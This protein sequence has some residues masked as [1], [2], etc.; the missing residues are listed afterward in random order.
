MKGED[1]V[2]IRNIK[3]Y[4]IF[5]SST[6]KDLIEE[7]KVVSNAILSAGHIPMGMELF[8]PNGSSS[9]DIIKASIDNSD[10]LVLIIAG[11][12]GSTCIDEGIE[13]SYVEMEYD[14][15]KK[16][17]K[18]I[19]LFYHKDISKLPMYKTEDS[20]KRKKKLAKFLSKVQEDV[21]GKEWIDVNELEKSVIASMVQIN[22]KEYETLGW[23]RVK[24]VNSDILNMDSEV[25]TPF[26]VFSQEKRPSETLQ[27]SL[28]A[29]ASKF[30][31]FVKTGVTFFSA[32]ERQ[33]IDIVNEGCQFKFLT[34]REEYIKAISGQEDLDMYYTNIEKTKQH[35]KRIINLVKNPYNIELRV[36]DYVPTLS[37]N[38]VEKKTGEKFIL[39]QQ[40]FITSRIGKDRP[41]FLL[42]SDNEWF[43]AY[44]EEIDGLWRKGTVWNLD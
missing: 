1:Q 16:N 15:A 37:I 17:N 27:S 44:Y 40:Y 10:F 5:V 20:K 19:L 25:C 30:Y 22:N 7:R 26:L 23:V 35:I 29:N 2:R 9:I 34:T 3:K 36:V 13:K 24:D 18:P 42:N 8:T 11:K 6:Y 21:L 12:Y 32:Y 14:Y 31:F 39:V 38:F 33:I 4:G 41:M 28:L 43:D